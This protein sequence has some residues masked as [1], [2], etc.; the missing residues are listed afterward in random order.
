[1]ADDAILDLSHLATVMKTHFADLEAFMSPGNIQVRFMVRHGDFRGAEA[2]VY[3]DANGPRLDFKYRLPPTITD[4]KARLAMVVQYLLVVLG[5]PAATV[6][7]KFVGGPK[8]GLQSNCELGQ[9]RSKLVFVG[10]PDRNEVYEWT[11]STDPE[12]R[13]VLAYWRSMTEDALKRFMDE[14][15]SRHGEITVLFGA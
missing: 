1:M 6:P 12:G 4:G 2:V 13:F 10:K 7:V 5:D 3:Q 15:V 14:G 8:D 11:C 9:L